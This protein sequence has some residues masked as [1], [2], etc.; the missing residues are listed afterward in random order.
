MYAGL[1]LALAFRTL[2]SALLEVAVGHYL[3]ARSYLSLYLIGYIC[4]FRCSGESAGEAE[5][6]GKVCVVEEQGQGALAVGTLC[7]YSISLFHSS[8]A[9]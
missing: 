1:L 4:S 8:C 6:F 3:C 7:D 5:P 9:F 2:L